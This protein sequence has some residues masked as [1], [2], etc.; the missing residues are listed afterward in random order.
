MSRLIKLQQSFSETQEED[1]QSV[2]L[3]N[4]NLS[5]RL[6]E[7]LALMNRNGVPSFSRQDYDLLANQ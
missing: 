3:V 5:A 7:V 1:I 6:D 4:K 2:K